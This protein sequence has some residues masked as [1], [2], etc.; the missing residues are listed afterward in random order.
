MK[1]RSRTTVLISEPQSIEYL[2]PFFPY[3]WSVLK[4]YWERHGDCKD[5]YE[6]LDPIFQNAD[7]SVLLQPYRD[8]QVDVLGLSCYTWNW[9]LQCRIAEWI[10]RNNT[11]CV[12]IAGGPEPDYKDPDFFCKYPFIDAVAVKDGEITFSKVLSK[13]ARGNRSFHDIRGLYLPDAQN[14]KP[15]CTGPAEVPT[16]FDYS[17]YLDQAGYYERFVQRHGPSAF[18]VTL[19]TNRGCPYSCSFCDWGSSTMSKLRR[20][21]MPRITSELDWLGRMQVSYIMLADANFG[22]LAR[23]LDIAECINETHRKYGHPKMFYYSAAKN[24]PDRVVSI[25]S[26]FAETG[27]SPTHMLAIQHTRKE[28]L[29]ATDRDNISA[30]KL[31]RAARTLMESHVPVTVQLICGIPGDTYDLWKS[32]LTDLMEWAIHDDY[33]I[34][35]YS[36][37]PNA[38]AGD[39]AFIQKWEIE[40]I[41]RIILTGT[42]RRW[43]PGD[44]DLVRMNK[45]KLIV[46][47]KTFS[48]SDWVKMFAYA[49]FVKA[50][51][52]GSLTRL[53]AVYLRLTHGVP[54]RE[55]YD[56]VIEEFCLEVDF[57]KR[58]YEAV[59][60]CYLRILNDDNM[61]DRMEISQLPR[62]PYALDPARW[63]YVQACFNIEKFYDELKVFL[64]KR[65]PAATNLKSAIDFQRQMV[66]L[67]TYDRRVGK[68]FETD[69]DW[70]R[71]F[72]GA[73]GRT[74]AE[75]LPEPD[76]V[77]G[78]V[79]EVSDLTCGEKGFLIQ[80]LDWGPGD[81]QDRWIE[82]IAHT[83]LLR[84]SAGKR[85]FQQLRL[86]APVTAPSA[87]LNAAA[88]ALR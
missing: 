60:N 37:L 26:K 49:T 66:I 78:A 70:V 3:M 30:E 65:F 83:I 63:L 77:A 29:S 80:A 10:K 14:G 85:N 34:Y 7:P 13:L 19:E 45:S 4:S 84:N 73:T 76:G 20:F 57:Y 71:Y 82:W 32:C 61:L 15:V 1:S 23:D 41:D 28:V 25:A 79:V 11:D 50:L 52:N 87:S 86:Q 55:F 72:K 56:R 47:A 40:T 2:A 38:P 88:R 67:P 51:H 36:V 8:V 42:H 35:F 75:S 31:V 59:S 64:C 12:V 27:V 48:R 81:A 24:D 43:K 62:Y 21:D 39:P 22:I 16:V 18:W 58:W 9:T 6:W 68:K 53:I 74:G 44:L 46:K 5:Y 54:Y 33:D 69:C 17:P